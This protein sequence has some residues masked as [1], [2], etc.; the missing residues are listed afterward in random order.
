MQHNSFFYLYLFDGPRYLIEL[1]YY[2]FPEQKMHDLVDFEP[3]FDHDPALIHECPVRPECQIVFESPNP[4]PD[5]QLPLQP[6]SH[7]EVEIA[8]V[9]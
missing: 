6:A 9:I 1:Y 4:A 5:D 2:Y 3:L 8:L 7:R